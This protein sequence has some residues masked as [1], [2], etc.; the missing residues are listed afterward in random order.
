MHLDTIVAP[1]SIRKKLTLLI[2]AVFVPAAGIIVFQ[3]M[4]ERKKTLDEAAHY[5]A[6][7]VESLAA[8]QE[9]MA[10]GTRQL[11]G[12]LAQLPQVRDLDTQACNHLLR[13]LRDRNPVYSEMA[14]S[15]PDGVMIAN[16]DPYQPGSVNISALKQV[17]D[18][19]ESLDFCV[20]ECTQGR[21]TSIPALYF[22]CPVLN[23]DQRL[24]AVLTAGFKLTGYGSFIR[25]VDL[26]QGWV[27]VI[28]D[29]KRLRLYRYPENI[30]SRLG[31]PPKAPFTDLAGLDE[32]T[33]ERNSDDGIKRLFA[34]KRLRISKSSPPYM[35]IEVGVPKNSILRKANSALM[36]NLSILGL[37]AGFFLS[38]AWFLGNLA[39]TRP[40]NL[41][42]NAANRFA[43]GDMRVRTGLP[44]SPDELGKLAQSFDNMAELL[45]RREF[46]KKH[47]EEELL[48]AH[49]RN[50]LILDMAQEGI[51]GLDEKGIVTFANTAA[52]STL[53]YE[54]GEL[55]GK[56]FHLTVHHSF[57]D[58]I[59][60]PEA[61]CPMSECLH[62]GLICQVRDEFLWKKDGAGFQAAYTAA[63]ITEYGQ[64]V[65]GVI[66][67]RDISVRKR[68][69]DALRESEERYRNIS[70]S[71]SN[72][73]FSCIR[74]SGGDYEINWLVGAVESI[75]GY[76]VQ[77]VLDNRCW[78]FFVHPDDMA[79]FNK[80]V[81]GL[82]PSSSSQCELRIL[83]KNGSVG[84]IRA[85]SRVVGSSG[86][87]GP[88]CL[89][90]SCEDI[91]ER[92]QAED[93]ANAQRDI[94]TKVF[95]NSPYIMILL[96]K[97]GRI[98]KINHK[99]IAFAGKPSEL[100]SD[101]MC[102]EAFN[103]V[104]YL[105]SLSCG[106]T[107]ECADCPV[108]KCLTQT[109]ETG[110]SICDTEGR[111]TV[112]KDSMDITMQMSIS[113]ALI[114]SKDTDQVLVT[115]ADITERARQ[116]QNI[117]HLNRLYSVLSRVSQAVV[118]AKS[119]ETFLEKACRE[120]VEGGGFLLAWIGE[121]ELMTGAVAP[122]ASWGSISEYLRGITVYADN[123]PEGRGPT[124][125]CIRENHPSV[126]NDFLHSPLTLP[127]R[128]R[129]APFGIASDAAFPIKRAGRVWGAL[130]VYSDE[131]DRFGDQDLGLLENIAGDIGF[132]LDNLDKESRR[133]QA[134]EVLRRSEREKTLSNRI[135]NVFL[136]ISDEKI[137]E[138]I[139]N[140]IIDAFKCRYGL[141]GYMG[142]KGD[143]I[144]PSM[145]RGV[146]SECRVEEKSGAFPPH[147]W[148]N[149][150]WG[151]AITEK[152]SFL[153]EG[154]FQT[155]GGHAVVHNFLTAPIL[156]N[157]MTIGLAALANK[158][159]G[160][161]AE[162]KAVLELIAERISPILH[163]R[164]QRDRQD[165]ERQKAQEA[166]RL[167]ERRLRKAEVVARSGNWEF[168]PGSGKVNAS[169][170]AKIIYGLEGNEWSIAEVQRIPLAEY[171]GMLDK[172]FN[173]LL[174]EGQPY[175][176]QFKVRRQ[177]DG[178]IIDVH[179]VAEY[180][181][182]EGVVFGVIH[183]ITEHQR[184][185][186]ERQ[187]LEE[188]LF[189][190]QKMESVG[191]L[192]GG[193]AHDFNN[194]LGVILGHSEMAMEQVD[195]T[196]PLHAD[197]K[198]IQ[199]AAERSAD[200]TRQLLAFARKQTIAPKVLDLNETVEGMLKMLRRLIGEDIDLTWLPANNLWPVKVDP[201]QI[202]QLLANLCV[203]A[204]DAIS[205]TG[206]I[207]I[208]SA[209]TVFEKEYCAENAGFIPGQYL[210]L[211]L[212]DNGCGMDKE[213]LSK[214]FEPFFT[215]KSLGEG[216]GLGLATVYGIVKQNNGFINVYSEPGQGT[217]FKIYLPR[218]EE[219]A[220]QRPPVHLKKD[221]RG[222]ETVL[223]VEDE[224]PM[225]ALGKTILLR[226][227]YEVLATQS[228]TEA[229]GIVQSYP[230][231]IHLLITDV[232]MPEMNGK[233]LRDKLVGL[234]PGLK[235]IFMSGY[236]ANV[237]A[238]HGILDENIDFLQKPFSVQTL[239]EKVRNVLE[240]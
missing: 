95:N 144:V 109:F 93:D 222:H 114:E 65:G 25:K 153:S 45:E 15:R 147:V 57:P 185:K 32:G 34:F 80:N 18:A 220:T 76:S 154:P 141:L 139:L 94:L 48:A 175:N 69:E 6:T 152:K 46:E 203:N 181:R 29:H 137:Y 44:H 38:L 84:W 138:E 96:A 194:M 140:V 88:H 223:L 130:L 210:L 37:A 103:C 79:I 105:D 22:A 237:I 216:T 63:P 55:I 240:G 184:A 186:E 176:V 42:V 161:T 168:I 125:T 162:D 87:L 19:K 215:T 122:I 228:P 233:D 86:I 136:T 110:R 163:T 83:R 150:I 189:Q 226:H 28:F 20:G 47:A 124:G 10:E 165:L 112:R 218:A 120:I 208:E 117:E 121:L 207:T 78:K 52:L 90:G 157:H 212:S 224:E 106:R 213:T 60:Y 72:F 209:N 142:D 81:V 234:N 23:S 127:W 227:G 16:A 102:A 201:G 5:A 198:E 107:A 17:R 143:L 104:N 145:T 174:E 190:S 199:K 229:L 128:D 232:V 33:Y 126:H 171:R 123:R 225:L 3:S 160:F 62:S 188:Q 101:L 31:L 49:R 1:W 205:A 200:L 177:S 173:G 197:L 156:F 135:F 92:K 116:A 11:L 73:A 71:I 21:L 148:G 85:A 54:A 238:H 58:G 158:D 236:T 131:V 64:L 178:K 219:Q 108:H 50:Q 77:E 118:R 149:T 59:R 182:E 41:L 26:P 166:L 193:V 2:L 115:M 195:S 70:N 221:L 204:R 56:N 111:M 27:V 235:S 230:G 170:G 155:P 68:A 132:A 30:A 119:P 99:G 231:P 61:E 183:D 40:I 211:A 74:P 164:I 129:A 75:T 134:E 206:K 239:L 35:L 39:F 53:G 133:R 51:V 13:A 12:T 191:R 100:L 97:D 202:D 172:A 196:Q 151:K 192:A 36:F 214:I 66:T 98:K 169:D 89:F 14:L 7:M 24:L 187:K 180:S 4:V 82:G 113:T 67:F 217:T 8:Q 159:G 43:G 167:S 179:S 91:T 146:W 9:R